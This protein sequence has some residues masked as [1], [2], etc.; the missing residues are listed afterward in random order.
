MKQPIRIDN[1]SLNAQGQHIDVHSAGLLYQDHQLL[2]E[3]GLDFSGAGLKID[4][5]AR[6]GDL[7]WEKLSAIIKA[8]QAGEGA[9]KGGLGRG[10]Y[11]HRRGD[12]HPGNGRREKGGRGYRS[13]LE[14][15][16]MVVRTGS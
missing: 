15:G 5:D 9:E 3:G 14:R 6:T 4:L 13:V 12:G 2:L 8:E 16:R 7:D 1:I 11:R 10:G